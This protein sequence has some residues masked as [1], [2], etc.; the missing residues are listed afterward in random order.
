MNKKNPAKNIF[1]TYFLSAVI[2]LIL[3]SVI[4]LTGFWIFDKMVMPKYT[5]TGEEFPMPDVT[6]YN[7]LQAGGILHHHGFDVSPDITEVVDYDNPPGR[8]LAQYPRAGSPCKKGRN[9]FLTV[10]TGALPIEVPDLIGLSPQDAGYRVSEGRLFLDSILYEFSTD[11]PEGVVMGQSLVARDSVQIGDS[12]YIVVSVGRHP[13]EYI[14]PDV[15]D[16]ILSRAAEI[17]NRGG[18]KISEIVYRKNEDYLPGTVLDQR[19]KPGETVY[20][21]A[22]IRLLVSSLTD[23]SPSDSLEVKEK[24]GEFND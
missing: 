24:A 12:L 8:V 10:S 1:K 22:E 18:F 16:L 14:I 23:H 5:R 13:A 20:L 11:F 4:S 17:I 6:G 9:V 19:P 21:G 7:I 2:S 15:K 3:I